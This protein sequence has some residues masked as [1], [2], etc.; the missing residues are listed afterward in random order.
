MDNY[1]HL[2][3][4]PLSHNWVTRNWVRSRKRAV[5]HEFVRPLSFTDFGIDSYRSLMSES[6]FIDSAI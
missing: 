4:S 5:H 6:T 1:A 2:T 3:K